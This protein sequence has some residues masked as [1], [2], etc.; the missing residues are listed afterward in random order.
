MDTNNSNLKIVNSTKP[1][2][3]TIL[4]IIS[5]IT[6]FFLYL[7]YMHHKFSL[8]IIVKEEKNVASKIYYNTLRNIA[9]R[10]ES[11]ANNILMDEDIIDAFENYDR[12]ELLSITAPIYK[13]LSDENP[14]LKIMHFH[15][16]DTKSFLRLHK[17]KK[18]G[19][20][21]SS[22]R[23]MINRVNETK[24]KVIAME[25]GRYGVYYRLALPISNHKG[26]HLGVF[27]FGININY[28]LDTF[29]Q[30][31]DFKSIL[32]LK[33]NI[34]NII[35]ENNKNITYNSYSNDYYSIESDINHIC[36]CKT[37][38]LCNCTTSPVCNCGS[39]KDCNCIASTIKDD[40]LAIIENDDNS[41][42]IFTINT[43]KDIS[44]KEIG[45]VLFIKNMNYYTDEINMIKNTSIASAIVLLFL[46]FY[47]MR[48][49]FNNYINVI[50]SYQSKLEIKN[51]TL[52]KLVN[53]DHLTK[54]HNR[55]S[56]ETILIKELKRVK[57]YNHELSV[58]IFDIDNFKNINDT[59]GHNTGDKVLKNIA[60]V[61]TAT[62][63]ET[64][65]FGRWGGEEF[66]IIST[67]T[68]LDNAL[69]VAEKIRN[70]IYSYDFEEAETVSC[71]VGVAEYTSEDTHQTIVHNADTAL[72]QAKHNGKNRVI[73]YK[74]V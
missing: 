47:L 69:L 39:D 1:M 72:Y 16:D 12:K 61:V 20:D 42:I 23:H 49:I 44:D 32:L 58:I 59:Y 2:F 4:G 19:D 46:S 33:K 51:R 57:R 60:K 24:K 67:E 40:K 7:G 28:I 8:D 29:N 50:N 25:A 66:I 22:I 38:A 43:I 13:K 30:N 36:T 18:F 74:N 27:E 52:L 5:F 31:Y 9:Q 35:Y 45:K 37:T 65:Y 17:P 6:I 14:Y 21:L 3:F 63:R 70:S 73:V 15:T 53:I 68:S 26:Q 56:I 41:N 11:V 54:I 48:K 55:K 64:D 62:I 10:Y 71:S 34:F